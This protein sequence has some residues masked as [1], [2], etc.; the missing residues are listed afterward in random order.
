[1]PSEHADGASRSSGALPERIGKYRIER[2]LGRGGMGMVY[3]GHD[4]TLG[5]KVAVKVI[6]EKLEGVENALKRFENEARLV[7]QLSNAHI[8]HVYEFD[9]DHTP[10]F[11]AMEYVDGI[12]LRSFIHHHGPLAYAEVLDCAKQVLAGLAAAHKAGITHRDIKPHN[13]LRARDGTYK[14]MD[15]GLARS[16]QT[17]GSLTAT[18]TI[19][20]TLHYLAPEVANGEKA[21]EKSDLYSLGVTLYEMLTG[22]APFVEDSPLKLIRRIATEK[23]TPVR[24]HRDDVP[25][26][27]E[28]WLDKLLAH[29]DDKRF[30]SA[31]EALA[32]LAGMDFGALP[33][34]AVGDERTEAETVEMKTP[35]REDDVESIVR[36]A[37]QLEEAGK[38]IL[39]EESIL[40]IARELNI[41]SDAVR[42]AIRIHQTSR[43][44]SLEA[45][46][47]PPK[48]K[49][50]PHPHAA[51]K[52]HGFPAGV[53]GCVVAV[54][55][56]LAVLG[57]VLGLLVFGFYIRRV[58]GDKEARVLR[59]VEAKVRAQRL[60]R[61]GDWGAQA[62]ILNKRMT[63]SWQNVS[64]SVALKDLEKRGLV[65]QL[66]V[67][68]EESGK[69]NSHVYLN[70]TN[71]PIYYILDTLLKPRGLTWSVEGGVVVIRSQTADGRGQEMLDSRIT[72]EWNEAPLEFVLNATAK[73]GL[74]YRVDDAE[75]L[76]IIREEKFS[77]DCT[78][79]PMREVLDLLLKPRG[80]AWRL[81]DDVVVIKSK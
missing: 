66:D 47:P 16:L 68:I 59:Q 54:V 51:K 20:G 71:Q 61:E 4:E 17:S 27:L 33:E 37:I 67:S 78:D 23:P 81:E 55:A 74:V 3:V 45:V 69:V 9:P 35:L 41:G 52:K 15:F 32:A 80:L 28:A 1:M 53:I 43:T 14:L 6:N 58:T 36:K 79:R 76:A 24:A 72:T 64:L 57:G 73:Q 25:P 75:A 63:F 2:S 18:G 30:A 48:P 56:C 77:G 49:G 40:E 70:V 12:D 29:E 39:R 11:L 38:D 50:W 22:K 44:V 42:Q 46:A 13:V 10:P 5:R 7:A 21:T 8:V 60:A 19:V 26:A 62:A 34:R 65:Y 31:E